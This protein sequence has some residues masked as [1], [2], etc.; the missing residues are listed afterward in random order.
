MYKFR[1]GFRYYKSWKKVH[2]L[3]CHGDKDILIN[4]LDITFKDFIDISLYN[5]NK[6]LII[7]IYR[8]D[9]DRYNSH[10]NHILDIEMFKNLNNIQIR[11]LFL[12]ND[13][14]FK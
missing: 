2:V 4:W 1:I 14:Y 9:E 5:K 11:E 13:E 7:T 10:K 6:P 8:N 12:N 3:H